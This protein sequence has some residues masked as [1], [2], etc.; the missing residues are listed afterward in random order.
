MQNN[1]KVIKTCILCLMRD[2][3]F[4]LFTLS[5]CLK[6]SVNAVSKPLFKVVCLTGCLQENLSVGYK[7][8]YL[9]MQAGCTHN[10]CILKLA[11]AFFFLAEK[12]FLGVSKLCSLSR[13]EGI[14]YMSP[15]HLE[16][17][18]FLSERNFLHLLAFF[19]IHL[20]A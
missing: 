19:L 20:G 16:I 11:L 1:L 4:Q 3:T 5:S 2:W 7:V 6:K 9:I 12:A 17:G 14:K 8:K 10:R 18:E 15:M 13:T